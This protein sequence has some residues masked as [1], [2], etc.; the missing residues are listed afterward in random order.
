MS[1]LAMTSKDGAIA[2]LR[3]PSP[4]DGMA[5]WK[6]VRDTQVLDVNSVY[7][8]VLFFDRF[9]ETCVVAEQEGRVVG[10][11]TGFKPPQDAE[12]IFVW[13][14]GVDASA[15]GQGL[16]SRML[17]RLIELPAGC[18]VHRMETTITP[19]NAASKALFGAFARRHGARCDVSPGYDG[20]LL[21]EAHESEQLYKIGPFA[22]RTGTA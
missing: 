19:S 9:R 4:G 10:F 17:D 2:T 20:S 22:S 7:Q 5:V 15:R 3:Q 13:Q 6:L 14:V 8:Y 18:D 11:V 21:G 16:A 12:T 1:A